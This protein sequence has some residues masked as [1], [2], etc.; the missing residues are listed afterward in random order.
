MAAGIAGFAV[1]A[2]YEAGWTP[3]AR[4]P[5]SGT[6]L[7]RNRAFVSSVA[8]AVGTFSGLMGLILVFSLFCQLGLGFSALRTGVAM[9]PFALGIALASPLSSL[10][11]PRIG[12]RVIQYGLLL[13][14]VG[15]GVV[16]AMVAV[17]GGATTAWDLVPGGLVTGLGMGLIFSPVGI[18]L[19]GLALAGTFA[20]PRYARA[21]P[22]H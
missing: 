6:A 18:G 4:R 12:R 9:A 5:W 17:S 10:L 20:M 15:L 2:A 22:A 3:G 14:A 19:L 7:L 21:E 13:A 11:A 8:V 1:F 16:T